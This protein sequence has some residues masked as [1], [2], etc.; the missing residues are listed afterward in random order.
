MNSPCT[1]LSAFAEEKKPVPV[2]FDEHG[3]PDLPTEVRV[4]HNPDKKNADLT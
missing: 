2:T 4:L 3:S 1:A